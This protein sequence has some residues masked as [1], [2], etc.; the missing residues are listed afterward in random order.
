MHKCVAGL[1]RIALV[2]IEFNNSSGQLSR[3]ADCGTF[4]LPLDIAVGTVHEYETNDCYHQHSGHNDGHGYQQCA[5]RTLFLLVVLCLIR[6]C[7]FFLFV[8]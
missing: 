2:G 8:C 5:V 4:H 3:N 6:H 1:H 7:I